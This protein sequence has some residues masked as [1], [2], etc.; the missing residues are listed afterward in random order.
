MGTITKYSERK[1]L[2]LADITTGLV[3]KRK[4]ANF[5]HEIIKK[6]KMLTLK[7]F[8][9]NGILV[10]E[11]LDDFSSL[12][13]IDS[14]YITREGDVIVR[15]ST[16]N[17]AIVIN[18]DQI[19]LLISSLFVCIRVNETVLSPAYLGIYLNGD[20][21]NRYYSRSITGSTIQIVKTS[22]FKDILIKFPD[23]DKQMEVIEVYELILREKQ[24]LKQ[25][26]DEKN[27]YHRGVLNK[28]IEESLQQSHFVAKCR[29]C[30]APLPMNSKYSICQ[31]CFKKHYTGKNVRKKTTTFRR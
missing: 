29:I 4:Q 12:E 18:K 7:S 20:V 1:L 17:T 13:E 8:T 10:T 30:Q 16:P 5:K 6:Y 31:S 28:F 3:V 25:L 11:N 14:K 15:L 21:V 26:V 19:G 24:L 23:V 2:D 9:N 22:M 27:E